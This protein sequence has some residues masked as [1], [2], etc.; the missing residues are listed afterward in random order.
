MFSSQTTKAAFYVVAILFVAAPYCGCFAGI[1]PHG[2]V[3]AVTLS[4]ES[5]PCETADTSEEI[6]HDDCTDLVDNAQNHDSEALLTAAGSLNDR[7]LKAPVPSVELRD[8]GTSR[9]GSAMIYQRGP[10]APTPQTL[11]QLSVLLL[12]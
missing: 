9:P 5:L 6:C 11:V 7:D 8:A 3:D 4:D 1:L 10:P 2:H 12:A